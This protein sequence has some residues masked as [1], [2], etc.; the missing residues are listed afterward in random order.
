[1]QENHLFTERG[2][3]SNIL[4]NVHTKS[5]ETEVKQGTVSLLFQHID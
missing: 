3:T 1:M 5:N 2:S 4:R